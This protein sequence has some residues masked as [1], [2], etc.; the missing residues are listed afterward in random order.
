MYYK[1]TKLG[2]PNL[3]AR[4]NTLNAG[5]ISKPLLICSFLFFFQDHLS[6]SFPEGGRENSS[7][8]YYQKQQQV[9]V[10]ASDCNLLDSDGDSCSQL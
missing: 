7:G 9:S 2:T 8:I 6:P 5:I 10:E 4:R 3:K 1:L